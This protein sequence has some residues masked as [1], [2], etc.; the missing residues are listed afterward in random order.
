M[1]ITRFSCVFVLGFREHMNFEECLD[2]FYFYFW[3]KK[4]AYLLGYWG[5]MIT[6]EPFDDLFSSVS[7]GFLVC[8]PV[9]IICVYI[10]RIINHGFLMRFFRV[11]GAVLLIHFILLS[12]HAVG[13][14]L[15]PFL[16]CRKR[17]LSLVINIVSKN[18]L[19]DVSTTQSCVVHSHLQF[20]VCHSTS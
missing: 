10:I 19:V 15:R 1:Q 3:T 18:Y 13:F 12:D 5:N 8:F 4:Q 6:N 11:C 7:W 2:Y 9:L 14:H 17:Y 16:E 20:V